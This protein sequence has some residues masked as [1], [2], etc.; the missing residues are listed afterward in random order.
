M[1]LATMSYTC[2]EWAMTGIM[3]PHAAAVIR[4]K[5]LNVND[6]EVAKDLKA[7]W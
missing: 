7:I 2:G 5:K 4:M 1:D 3:C 6:W